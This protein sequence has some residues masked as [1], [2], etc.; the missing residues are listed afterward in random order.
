MTAIL[1]ADYLFVLL[2]AGNLTALS[3]LIRRRPRL[4]SEEV[5]GV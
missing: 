1:A 4:D 2:H 3:N 5:G